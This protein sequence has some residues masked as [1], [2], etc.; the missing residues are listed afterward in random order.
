[1]KSLNDP[2]V[3]GKAMTQVMHALTQSAKVTL[4]GEAANKETKEYTKSLV[5]LKQMEIHELLKQTEGIH[6]ATEQQFQ[7][8]QETIVFAYET[9]KRATRQARQEEA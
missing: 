2:H 5:V 1:M 9:A 7:L 3:L 8:H 6:V 4:L